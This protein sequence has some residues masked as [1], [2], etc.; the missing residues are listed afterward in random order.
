MDDA[1]GGNP[2]GL[3]RPLELLEELRALIRHEADAH[4][5]AVTER[6]R[7][8][9]HTLHTY[10][11]IGLLRPGPDSPRRPRGDDR[12][13]RNAVRERG[14]FEPLVLTGVVGPTAAN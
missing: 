1:P 3:E 7:V 11:E 5:A 6:A 8:T 2:L 9:V 4:H 14:G 10:D 12:W 13:R